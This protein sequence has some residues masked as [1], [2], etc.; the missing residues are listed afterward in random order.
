MLLEPLFWKFTLLVLGIVAIEF[1]AVRFSALIEKEPG[2][3][4][5]F[6]VA[7]RAAELHQTDLDLLVARNIA[8]LAGAEHGGQKI[9]ILDRNIDFT[10]VD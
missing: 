2:K 6:A 5:V 3:V 1:V 4:E 10:D 9:G 7:G 8:A